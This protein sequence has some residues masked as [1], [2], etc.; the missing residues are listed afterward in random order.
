MALFLRLLVSMDRR[1]S[2]ALGPLTNGATSP[3]CHSG[4]PLVPMVF[5]ALLMETCVTLNPTK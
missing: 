1:V 4:V 2:N 5:W 3:R